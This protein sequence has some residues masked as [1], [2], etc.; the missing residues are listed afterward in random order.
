MSAGAIRP[1]RRSLVVL[2][3]ML[4]LFMSAIEVTIVATAMP[5][6]VRELGGFALY[7]WVFSAF[8]LTQTATTVTGNPPATSTTVS[9]LKPLFSYTFKVKATNAAGTGPES[10]ASNAVTPSGGATVPAEPTAVTAAP[11]NASALVS[12]TAPSNGGSAITGYK[13]T[14]YLNGTTAQTTT[15][16]DPLP[17][18]RLRPHPRRT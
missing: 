9:G 12:W 3:I 15:T 1:S 16:T 18:L 2:C 10:A 5:Q 14:P 11:R 13:V 6:I 8:L 4:S 17:R 7:A